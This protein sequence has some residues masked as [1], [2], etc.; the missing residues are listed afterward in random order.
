MRIDLMSDIDLEPFV[1][2]KV[3]IK[4]ELQEKEQGSD[5]TKVFIMLHEIKLYKK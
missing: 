5:F 3:I 2:K 4:G 1:G